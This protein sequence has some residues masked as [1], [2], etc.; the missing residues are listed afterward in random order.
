MRSTLGL[1][2]FLTMVQVTAL[3]E[4]F[5]AGKQYKV[6]AEPIDTSSPSKIEVTVFFSYICPH[7][8]FLEPLERA[9]AQARPSDVVVRR[10]PVVW[11]SFLVLFAEAY[12]VA[13]EKGIEP[14]LS[15]M[16]SAYQ[17]SFESASLPPQPKGFTSMGYGRLGTYFPDLDRMQSDSEYCHRATQEVGKSDE[18]DSWLAGKICG[19]S[20]RNWQLMKIGN[21]YRNDKGFSKELMAEFFKLLGVNNFDENRDA[22]I[23]PKINVDVDISRRAQITGT[24]AILVNGKYLVMASYEGVGRE[25][26][27]D[28]VDYLVDVERKASMKRN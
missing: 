27:F 4:P 9:W 5:D 23:R 24:P 25:K 15:D 20:R 8:A 10:V 13:L 1:L 22:W 14:A 7:C 2:V 28:V 3:A 18:V 16:L 11:N 19:A 17:F 12:Y 6:L 21:K 26:L